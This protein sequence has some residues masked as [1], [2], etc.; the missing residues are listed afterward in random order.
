MILSILNLA[1]SLVLLIIQLLILKGQAKLGQ[2]LD[3]QRE[4]ERAIVA[5]QGATTREEIRAAL[6][7]L[8][9]WIKAECG[10]T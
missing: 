6:E 10:L 7:N 8:P 9:A 5:L 1:L 3:Q 2:M 4:L